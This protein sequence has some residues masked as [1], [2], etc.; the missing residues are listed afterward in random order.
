MRAKAYALY[1]LPPNRPIAATAGQA[2]SWSA[3]AL[4]DM[5]FTW[6]ERARQRRVLLTLEDYR[7]KDIGVSR[8]DAELEA[9]KPF[10]RH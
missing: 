2:S 10:W 3:A 9:N 5:L 7:L 8:A 4:I 6:H 1:G